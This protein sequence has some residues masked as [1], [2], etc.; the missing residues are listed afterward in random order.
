MPAEQSREVRA[1]PVCGDHAAVVLDEFSFK[2]FDGPTLGLVSRLLACGTCGMVYNDTSLSEAQSEAWYAQQSLYAAEMGVGSGGLGTW[3]RERYAGVLDLI[4]AYLPGPDAAIFDVGCAKGG[5]LRYLKE[6]GYRRIHGVDLSPDCVRALRED[7][8]VAAEVGSARRLPFADTPADVLVLSHLLEHLQDPL[9][10]LAHARDKLTDDGILFVELPDAS[11]Y[12]EFPVF[13]L[14]WIA[15]REHINH[16]GAH[17]LRMLLERSGFSVLR[18]GQR[19]MRISAQTYNPL[20]YAICRRGEM[21]RDATSNAADRAMVEATRSYLARELAR[22]EAHKRSI[23]TV[24]ASGRPTFAWGIGLEFFCLY[25]IGGLGTCNLVGLIDNNPA[26][27]RRTVGGMH[28][29]SQE[30]LRGQSSDTVV[31]IT[32]ALHGT[33]MAETLPSLSFSGEVLVLG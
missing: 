24:A 32:S 23:A 21:Q 1:C 3:D 19:M 2:D 25:S 29:E 6:R 14:Y 33:A 27:Q 31:V 12:E 16:F 5:F 11:R 28:I 22:L 15:Q 8:G 17:H 13:D 20:L 10:A 30:R 18:L 4:E 26:K 9:A 7:H